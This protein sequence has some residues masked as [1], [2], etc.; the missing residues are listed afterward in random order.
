MVLAGASFSLHFRAA[1]DPKAYWRSDELRL[2]LAIV[3]VAAILMTI[4][5]WG[6]AVAEVIR[7]AVFTATS[8]I[9]TT[10]YA[11]TDFG[12]WGPALQIMIVGLMFIGGMAG[13]TAG[14]VK[15]Y[16]LEVLYEA[17][18]ADV[19]RLIHPRAVYVTRVGRDP[20]PEPI[21][22]AIQTFFLLYMFAFMTGTF[23]LGVIGSFG[24]PQLDPVTTVS[25]VASS[26]G[27]IGPGLGLVGPTETY[28][29]VP[30]LGKWLLAALMIVGRLEIL[31]ILIL[32]NRELWRR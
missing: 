16:R 22:E 8:I 1:R 5:T 26:L 21:I 3:G 32:F 23:L 24:D 17:S 31:P 19:R 29:V 20:V 7:N 4:G 30:A 13:S 2:Y 12:L 6:G 15:V 27:N 10:G 18:R 9:T 28:L 11:T 25:A 14:S